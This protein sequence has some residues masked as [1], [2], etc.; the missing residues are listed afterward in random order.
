MRVA[1]GHRERALRPAVEGAGT[2]ACAGSHVHPPKSRA[3]ARAS[4]ASDTALQAQIWQPAPGSKRGGRRTAVIAT[5]ITKRRI[6]AQ[7]VRRIAA[8][9]YSSSTSPRTPRSRC[10]TAPAGEEQAMAVRSGQRRPGLL[11]VGR[12]AS[13]PSENSNTKRT[14]WPAQ[15]GLNARGAPCGRGQ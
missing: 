11:R 10:C 14:H 13:R 15:L 7:P 12:L 1:R 5:A 2:P 9:R 8:A 3:P 4:T 6:R